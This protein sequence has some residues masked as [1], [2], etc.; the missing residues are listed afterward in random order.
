MKTKL[1]QPT[2]TYGGIDVILDQSH[3]QSVA[4][5]HFQMQNIA[6]V[7]RIEI[8]QRGRERTDDLEEAD[9]CR[10]SNRAETAEVQLSMSR[11]LERQGMEAEHAGCC[12]GRIGDSVHWEGHSNHRNPS[13]SRRKEESC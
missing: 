5:V 9:R 2:S 12:R 6:N 8:G 10:R 4:S 7:H 11:D 1:T 3:L 13:C